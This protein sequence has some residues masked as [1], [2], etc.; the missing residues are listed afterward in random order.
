MG[1]M[2]ILPSSSLLG[3]RNTALRTKGGTSPDGGSAVPMTLWSSIP[4]V[5]VCDMTKQLRTASENLPA[6]DF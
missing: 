5:R 3:P 4:A 1:M 2:I 6:M